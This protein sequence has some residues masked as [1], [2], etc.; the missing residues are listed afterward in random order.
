ME[1]GI[2]MSDSQDFEGAFIEAI[3]GN[4]DAQFFV[5]G[6]SYPLVGRPRLPLQ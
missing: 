1:N 2:V 3:Q 6:R 5:G 4:A